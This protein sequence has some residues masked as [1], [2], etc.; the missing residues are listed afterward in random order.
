MGAVSATD[1]EDSTITYSIEAG[2]SGGLFAIDSGTGALSY[3]GAG[4]DY[5]SGTTSYDLTVRASDGGLHSDVTVAVNVTDVAEAPAF[6]QENYTFSL[7]ENAGG[8]TI[9]L[10]LGRVSAAD[11]EG[12]AVEYSLVAG[13]GAGLFELDAQTGDL[14]YVGSG[15]DYES[16][17]TRFELTV[18]ASDGNLFSD[19]TMTIDVT[20]VQ[21]AP[22]FGQ[23]NYAFSLTENAGGDTI[24]LSLGR[25]SAADPEGVDVE[26]SLVAGNG[27]GLF[28]LDA[29]TGDLFYVG[30]GEDYESGSTRFELTVRASDGGLFADA[31]MTIDVTDVPELEPIEQQSVSEPNGQDLPEGASTTGRV[32]VGGSATGEI[33]IGGDR[34]W[35][36]V[37]L[38][39]GRTY[40]IDLE[41]LETG[42]GTLYFPALRG[43]YNA[44][45]YYFP[46]TTND[47][48]G[49][50][51]HNSR[52][53]VM[54]GNDATYYVAAGSYET[55]K[56]TYTLSVMDVTDGVPDDFEDGT[57]TSGSVEVGGSA[58]GEIDGI[59]AGGDR[60]WFAVELKAGRLYQ[61]DLEGRHTG[62]GTVREPYLF[63]VHDANGNYIANT[64]DQGSGEGANSR[65]FFTPQEDGAYYVAARAFGDGEGTYTL[66]VT[67]ATDSGL[68]D[69]TAD[70]GT[71]GTVA[72]DGSATG[73]IDYAHDRDWFAVE[74]EAGRIYR[75]D[76]KGSQTGD[77]TLENP[78][79]RG[80][81]DANGNLLPGTTNDNAGVGYNSRVFFTA[82]EA[83]AY[84]VAASD[85]YNGRGTYTLSI[86]DVT[87]D[88]PDDFEAGTGT[89]G[90]VA[91]GGSATGD[92][93]FL[94]DHDWFAVTLEAGATYRIDLKGS[95]T[96]DGT[97]SDLYLY[98]VYDADGNY[99]D[100]TTNDDGGAHANSR[101]EFTAEDAGAYY[102]AAGAYG[103]GKGTY[104]LSV[105]D[106]TDG[107][108]DDFSAGTGTSGAVAVGGSATGEIDFYSDRDW[109][110]VT[111]EAGAT[112]RIDLKGSQTG[113]GTL[114]DPVLRGVYDADGVR[115]AGTWDDDSGAGRNS[116][117]FF[118]A[119]E[120][121]TY[122]VAAGTDG[123]GEGAYTLSVTEIPDDF[124]AGTD[125]TGAVEVG[126]SATGEIDFLGDRDWF[127]VTLE[128]GRTYWIDLK[129]SEHGDGTLVKSYLFG[130]HDADGNRLPGTRDDDS[131]AG[132]NSRVEFTA[133]EDATYYVAAGA[134]F[135]WGVGT[136][137]LSVRDVTD[138]IP[139]DFEAGTGTS[140]AVEVDGSATGEIEF[141]G[142]RDWFAVTLEAGKVYRVD[143]DGSWTGH[144]NLW[145]PY[146]R[147]V[148]DA[149]GVLIPGTTNDNDGEGTNSRVYFTAED[150]G[151]Y[152]VAAGAWGDGQ[153][154]YTLSVMDVAD[155]FPDDFSDGIGTSGS[156][157]V[158]GSATGEIE[159]N[160]DRDWFAVTLEANTNYRIDLE[161][162]WTGAGTLRDPYLHG[163]HD[164]NGV[165]IAGT[166]ADDG[167]TGWNSRMEFTADDTGT[168]Y[169][170]TG[171]YGDGQGAYRLSVREIPDDFSAGTGTTGTVDVGGSATGEIEF[172]RDRD[173]F[174][175]ELEANTNYRID[176]EGSRTGAGTLRDPYLRGVHDANGVRLPGTTN[177]NG[178]VARNSRVEFTVDDAGAYYVAAGAGG[179]WE[180]AYR[181]SVRE[182]P[183]DFSAG[184]GT[185]GTVDVG[186][187][188]TGEIEFHRDRDWFA[189]ELEAN[190]TYRIDLE[191]YWTGAGT[192]RDPYLRGV[193]DADGNLLPGTTADDGGTDWNS[194]MEFTADD[195]GT[196]YVAAGAGG[197]WEGAYTL[198]VS[199]EEVM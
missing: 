145:D 69:F 21:E 96:G 175:V 45:G 60:D 78:Y 125:T 167:G 15:E 36:A 182:V 133:E 29:Q 10:S 131:G 189:V 22:A 120:D 168:Y 33:E 37:T 88:V 54:A 63:G 30:S 49:G 100:N 20:D 89:S 81:F 5:E 82:E 157:E 13:N 112:Y 53:F 98:G 8:D 134:W 71:S 104:T 85:S 95:W 156:V 117:V 74:L 107:V 41:G 105:V 140:G 79:L 138:G 170:A 38:E 58:T 149:N 128:A 72:M 101:V 191:G 43:I 27:A 92:I 55:Y 177:D 68:D 57:G 144:G 137:T 65:V 124:A 119:K 198:S 47:T 174:A 106:I 178:G 93:E 116:R 111:L 59:E 23:E 196:Y 11:P 199:V 193:H 9:R 169:V 2:D 194:R 67:D 80:I 171:A 139:D 62:A 195:A 161:G 141:G 17:S 159:F 28:E 34:D 75:I 164:A 155:T 76:L 148:H 123:D 158:G 181:L 86:K 70:T 173:W 83:G 97:L 64:T 18:R 56:G 90:S 115:L 4:E 152:Y 102:V 91:V 44:N 35:F 3:Q 103:S 26:Y 39:A 179:T 180:G 166:T 162:Y 7:T 130:L 31:T 6:G 176:L 50:V 146:L 160:R 19:A 113:N 151:A 142:D 16:G 165:L 94:G 147:G 132:A 136:Y 42:A 153:G 192:L 143:L 188:A 84:Y 108:P 40:R 109:F 118:K 126:G 32:A 99:F 197:T 184:T 25:V 73:E 163:V 121:A 24:R 110:A 183:D 186:G 61:I 66:S 129:G 77:G 51:G 114:Y 135:D 87:T 14:F 154:T 190:T 185:T 1:P 172:N 48:G 187:S 46:G 52:L 12:V 127:A 122:Y 150:A